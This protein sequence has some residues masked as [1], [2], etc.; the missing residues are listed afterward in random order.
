MAQ[1]KE[2]NPDKATRR[3]DDLKLLSETARGTPMGD[4]LRQFWQPIAIST[5][6][7]AGRAKSL[8]IFSEELTLYRGQSGEPYLVGGRCAHRCTQLATGW[9]E[10]EEIRCIYHGWKY[11][12][13]G[14]C[15]EMPAEKDGL[16]ATVKI[17][18]YPVEE[19][20]GLVFAYLGE[21]PAPAFELP[22]KE[23]FERPDRL[24]F[25][26]EQTWPAN[27]FQQVENSMDAVHVSFVHQKGRVGLFGAAITPNIPD[28]EYFETD[29]GI[30]QVA[31]RG[32]NNVRTSDWTFPNNNHILV[33]GISKAHPW[34][35]IGVWMV[36]VDDENALRFQIYSVP[37]MGAEEDEKTRAHFHKYRNYDPSDH[38]S[39]LFEEEIYPE[40]MALELVNAQDYVAAVGQGSIVDRSQE[41]L[42]S[43]DKGIALLRRMFVREMEA[44]Q[45]GKPIKHWTPLDE[46]IEMQSKETIETISA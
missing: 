12:Q 40:E 21:G 1:N 45:T 24:I 13:T 31:T 23:L 6:V 33:P 17:A 5:H 28:L 46:T 42:V 27:W 20:C 8:K 19:Y 3:F 7:E 43:S 29:A 11:D 38:H 18:G 15:V 37:S 22:K 9:V 32:N 34:M 30:R 25:V 41:R 36:A 44:L 39:E 14:Q 10:G 35:D 4:L 2:T 26:R 16:A